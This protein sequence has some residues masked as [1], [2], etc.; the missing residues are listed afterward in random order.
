MQQTLK[1]INKKQKKSL[2]YKEKSLVGL[3]PEADFFNTLI[4]IF[5]KKQNIWSVESN[6]KPIIPNF[7]AIFVG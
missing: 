1:L 3:I 2:F 4:V 6:V 5:A 7:L